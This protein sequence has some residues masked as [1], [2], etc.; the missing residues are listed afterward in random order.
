MQ[1]LQRMISSMMLIFDALLH[2]LKGFGVVHL[3]HDIR[4]TGAL[5]AKD[6]LLKVALKV[7]DSGKF[8]NIVLMS[9]RF[10]G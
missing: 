6:C 8:K 9:T 10:S 2:L 4:I 7:L 5:L 1:I 3:F